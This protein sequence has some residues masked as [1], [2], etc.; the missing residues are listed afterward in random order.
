LFVANTGGNTIGE[1]TTSGAVVNASLVSGLNEPYGI[2]VS[3]SDL[4]VVNVNYSNQNP[5]DGTIGEYTTSGEV[6]NASLV[7]GLSQP[8]CIALSGSDLFV[9]NLGD[10]AYG[11]TIGEYTTSGAVVNASLVSGLYAP[12][13]IAVVDTPEPSTLALLA[14][15]AVGLL[16][17]GL[18]R[19]CAARRTAQSESND[20]APAILRC[21]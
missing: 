4:F 13:G 8:T 17:Y 2:A 3:G 20:D 7:S 9:A 11:G 5:S 21:S 10:S 15:G 18:R 14:T 16:G 1:Y 6:L 12:E 19:R